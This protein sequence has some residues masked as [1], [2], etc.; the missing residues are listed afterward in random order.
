[1]LTENKKDMITMEQYVELKFKVPDDLTKCTNEVIATEL[2]TAAIGKCP[3][4]VRADIEKAFSKA[5]A[6]WYG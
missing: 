1:M 5:L 3:Q 4:M 6:T 2:L